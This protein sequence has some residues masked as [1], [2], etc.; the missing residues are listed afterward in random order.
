MSIMERSS[1]LSK[2]EEEEEEEEEKTNKKKTPLLITYF[3]PIK[4]SFIKDDCIVI[5]STYSQ[6][7]HAVWGILDVC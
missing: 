2:E 7:M 1:S 4:Q 6:Q 5:C 3:C